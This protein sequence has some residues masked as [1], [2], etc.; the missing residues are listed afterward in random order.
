MDLKSINLNVPLRKT[1]T[2]ITDKK[3]NVFEEVRDEHGNY[4]VLMLTD[5]G[6]AF[7]HIIYLYTHYLYIYY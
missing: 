5:K 1:V 6:I 3:G 2:R 4:K 7:R